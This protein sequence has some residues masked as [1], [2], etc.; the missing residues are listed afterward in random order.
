MFGKMKNNLIAVIL[1]LLVAGLGCGPSAFLIQS[2]PG[3][4]KL[5][6]T[7]IEKDKGFFVTNKIAI[8]DVDG[9]MLNSEG[10]SLFRSTDNQV[11]L[12]V[13]KLDKARRDK[14]VKAVV[15]R[16][17]SPGGTVGA[18]D[19][20]YH[21]LKL[22]KKRCKKPV[23]ACMLD[24]TASG[25]Y[26]LACGADGIIAQ[27]STVTGS[28]GT[29]IQT[30]NVAGTMRL[31]GIRT[32]AIKSGKLKDIG[33]PYREMTEEERKLIEGLINEFYEQFLTVVDQ[34]RP[35]LTPDQVRKLADGRI[36]T[37][38]EALNNGLIDKTGYPSQALQ[39]AKKLASI[40]KARVVMYHRPAGYKPNIYSSA[41][42]DKASIGALV[43]LDLPDWLNSN[44]THFLYLWQPGSE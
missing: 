4:R 38:K 5:N 7:T 3:G 12:F 16:L 25:A 9:I 30:V 2:V 42:Y 33:S 35:S 44:G 8:I 17:N 28:I 19:M 32:Q 1:F 22:F 36:F 20:M 43:N 37:A 41:T 39:W 10:G 34:G 23:I 18:S 26:Y 14:A 31:L 21:Q 6:E 13:E 29:I 40:K 15:L 24:V 11:S 27:P